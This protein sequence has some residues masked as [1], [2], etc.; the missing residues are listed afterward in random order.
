ME[1]KNHPT[2]LKHNDHESSEYVESERDEYKTNVLID[3]YNII[4]KQLKN[5]QIDIYTQ[6]DIE[7]GLTLIAA[8]GVEDLL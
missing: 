7:S 2:H 6:E 4:I 8:T 5:D 1:Y 3:E